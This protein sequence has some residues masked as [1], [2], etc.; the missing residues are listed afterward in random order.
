MQ[1]S[2][3][4]KVND[5]FKFLNELYPTQTAC[6]FDN[7]GMLIGDGEAEVTKALISLDCTLDTV[8]KANAMECQLIITHHPVIFS[9]LKN[10]TA[11]TVAYAL[12]RNGISVI[13]MHTNLDTGSGGVNDCLCK[14]LEL[15]NI[16]AYTAEDGYLLKYGII[17]PI[18]AKDFAQ[19][20]KL[21]LSGTVKYVD[22]GRKIKKV[23]VCSGSGGD[24]LNE[25]I[26]GGFDAL[27]TADVKHHLFLTAKD[28]GI[29]LFDAGHFNTEDV[30][31]EPLQEIL[32]KNLTNVSF[33]TDH[34]SYI[35]YV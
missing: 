13:S 26:K 4:V 8:E 9:P 29:S 2:D 15:E 3:S 23:L 5:I 14:A 1:R 19:K 22:G 21:T 28:N 25:A 24:F 20:I 10:I 30:V 27:V 16:T 31:I 33:V 18:S 12:I 17:P 32:Q 6:D 35:S 7:P 34:T 11:G